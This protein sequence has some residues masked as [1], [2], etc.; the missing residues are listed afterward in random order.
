[1]ARLLRVV[2]ALLVLSATAEAQ[3]WAGQR[4]EKSPRHLEY[5]KLEHGDRV[6]NCFVAYPEVKEKVPAVVVVHEIFG[7]AE[8]PRLLADE[9]AEAGFV[10]IVPDLLSGTGPKG[11]GTE[12]FEGRDAVT[13]AVRDLPQRQ[14][15]AD[16]TAAVDY[17]AKLPACNGK[18]VVGGFCWGGGQAFQFAADSKAVKAAFVFYGPG[19]TDPAALGRIGAPVYGFYGGNDARVT[20]TVP[21]SAELMKAAGKVFEPT[22]YDEAGHGFMRGGDAPDARPADRKARD[23]AWQRLKTVMKKL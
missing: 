6:V 22:V 5:V 15:T 21:K 23:A 12:S 4:L 16:L 11:G 7:L 2:V 8:W 20:A 3:D 14:V 18:V 1:M 17:V 10:A 19:P 13:R 9:L